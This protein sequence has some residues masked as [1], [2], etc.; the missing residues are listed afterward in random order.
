MD[1]TRVFDLSLATSEYNFYLCKIYMKLSNC[2]KKVHLKKILQES[3]NRVKKYTIYSE[4]KINMAT[5]SKTG[6]II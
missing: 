4:L 6:C 2:Y 3:G 5:F 1:D